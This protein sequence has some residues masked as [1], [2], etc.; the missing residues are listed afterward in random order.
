LSSS[1]PREAGCQIIKINGST[2]DEKI[3]DFLPALFA[4]QGL[5]HCWPTLW[6]SSTEAAGSI[7]L[8]VPETDY[9]NVQH[10]NG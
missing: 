8:L 6:R 7:L 1:K 4:F 10:V 5:L 2:S 9:A 3:D